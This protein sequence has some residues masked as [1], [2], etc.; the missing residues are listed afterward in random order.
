MSILNK[1]MIKNWVLPYLYVPQRG[2]K[3]SKSALLNVV[4]AIFYRLKTGCHRVAWRW[5]ELPIKQFFDTAYTWH[6]VYHHFSTWCAKGC[7]QKIWVNMLKLHT[8]YLDMSCIGIDGSH[9]RSKMGGEKTGYQGRKS[10][11]T[12]NMLYLVDNQ[13][14]IVGMGLP[15]SGNHHDLFEIEERFDEL[16]DMLKDADIPLKGLFLNADAGF[17]CN[18]FRK[19][20]E[21]HDI[22]PNIAF[23]SAH[24]KLTEREEYFDAELY[25]RRAF[26]E[27]PFAWMDAFKALLVRYETKANHWYNLNIMGALL[28]F[29]RKIAHF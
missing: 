25:K 21:T 29:S 10:A 7:W 3:L 6:G 9:S 26:T 14:I 24:G 17:D 15:E 11:K 1:D 8:R 22:I 28:I 16:L 20:C 2:K 5:R 27:H 23:N 19:I 12:T 18:N 4:E 13:G